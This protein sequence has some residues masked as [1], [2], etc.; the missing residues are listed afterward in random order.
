MCIVLLRVYWFGSLKGPLVWSYPRELGM[1]S[2]THQRRSSC[3]RSG[4]RDV[5]AVSGLWF[6]SSVKFRASHRKYG[7]AFAALFVIAAKHS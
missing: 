1:L 4:D 6:R 3:A 2:G 5:P 7:Q